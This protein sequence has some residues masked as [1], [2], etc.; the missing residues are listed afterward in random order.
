MVGAAGDVVETCF[1]VRT[2]PLEREPVDPLRADRQA[3]VDWLVARQFG[4]C[5]AL[6]SFPVSASGTR[7][8]RAQ[9]AAATVRAAVIV[10]VAS[11]C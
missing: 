6:Q 10:A 11:H 1:D 4:A 8:E 5:R 3:H 9:S 7:R 2:C